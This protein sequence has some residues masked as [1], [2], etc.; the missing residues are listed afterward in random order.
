MVKQW[1]S[2]VPETDDFD[3]P[4]TDRFYDA[5]TYM[6]PWAIMN[7]DSFDRYQKYDSLG[8]GKGQCYEKQPDG[9]WIKV[10]G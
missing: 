10:G 6:G 8:V 9:S 2:P 5:K 4:I 1:I 7:Q 3:Q